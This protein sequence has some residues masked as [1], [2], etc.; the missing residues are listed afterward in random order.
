MPDVNKNTEEQPPILIEHNVLKT[1][2][3]LADLFDRQHSI[4]QEKYGYTS[5][6][7]TRLKNLCLVLPD[8]AIS[9]GKALLVGVEPANV[10]VSDD[11]IITPTTFDV[12]PRMGC[13]V[14]TD[15]M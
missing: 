2:V 13:Y 3:I 12:R 14:D 8:V 9:T 1:L 4:D 5:V 7:R 10:S 15:P 6:L 11:G